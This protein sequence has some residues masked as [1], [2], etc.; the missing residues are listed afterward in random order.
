MNLIKIYF[1]IIIMSSTVYLVAQTSKVPIKIWGLQEIS[2]IMGAEGE[3]K[4]QNI[5]NRAT[6][7]DRLES[8]F[9]KGR[10]LLNTQSYFYHPNLV[11]LETEL[12]YNPGKQKDIYLILPNRA[13][14]NTGEKARGTITFIRTQPVVVSGNANYTH[15][16]TSREYA[17]N[18]ESFNSGFGGNLGYR[19]N[20]APISIFYQKEKIDQRELQTKRNYLTNRQNIRANTEISFS[21]I[22]DH[23]LTYNYDDYRREYFSTSEI[24][25]EVSSLSMTSNFKFDSNYVNTLNSNVYYSLNTGDIEYNRLLVNENLKWD[26]QSNFTYSG[27]YNYFNFD[28]NEINTKQ[29]TILNRIEH[30]LYQS[31][32]TNIFYEYI[33][34]DQTFAQEIINTGGFG[35]SYT[36]SIPMGTFNLS[37]N[38]KKRDLNNKNLSPTASIFNEEYNMKDD[39]LIL[40][41]SPFID[42]KSIRVKDETGTIVYK[43]FLDYILIQRDDFIEIQRIQGGLIPN[44]SKIFVDYVAREQLSF[45][46]AINSNMFNSRLLLFNNLVEVYF[47]LNEN[48]YNNLIG[49]EPTILKSLSQRI[50]GSK[51]QLKMLTAGIEFDDYNSNVIP[52]EAT[53]YFLT[54]NSRLAHN[55]NASIT[56]NLKYIELLKESEK[57]KFYDVAARVIYN[58]SRISSLNLEASHRFQDG[59]GLDLSLSILRGELTT[60]YRSIYF[61]LGIEG[62]SRIY[63]KEKRSY[64]GS[65]LRIERK[66]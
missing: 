63:I 12:E 24:S 13:D 9:I 59:R 20:I 65:F 8:S 38:F 52:Y 56:G 23:K 3:Y 25:S 11:S 15:L 45:Q 41:N 16:Y 33:N 36:K 27:N 2:G 31:L 19:N 54:F 4:L 30:Q 55:F 37:Y 5:N 44:E 61:T 49:R 43:E 17:T 35:I 1:Q 42:I 26:L 29:H 22:D 7:S 58:F 66:F 34:T 21:D 53:R 50:F 6:Y 46:Y 39:G 18:L 62:Y 60:K 51:I 57:Q 10:F 47:I 40:L 48:T 14:I 28:Q 32:Q 64:W